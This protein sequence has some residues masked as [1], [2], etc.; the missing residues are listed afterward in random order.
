MDIITE[1]IGDEQP[2]KINPANYVPKS[3][4]I[5]TSHYIIGG[6][7]LVA[8]MS[9]NTSIKEVIQKKLPTE[10]KALIM[11]FV[12]SVIIT[13][14]LV[15]LIFFLPD[16]K[17]ELPE[18]TQKKINHETERQEMLRIIRKQQNIIKRL[19]L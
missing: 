4:A 7:A 10:N 5:K 6:F 19:G 8:A 3:V 16:T 12:Y 18:S 1:E 14:L 2:A 11:N 15:L 17:E 9:W 13:I